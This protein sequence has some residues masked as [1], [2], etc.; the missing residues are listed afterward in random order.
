MQGAGH[1]GLEDPGRD[2][3]QR[4]LRPRQQCRDH[5]RQCRAERRPQHHARRKADLQHVT[6]IANVENKTG[7]VQGFFVP[8]S[9]E[10]G[11]NE[12]GKNEAGK[13][14]PAKPAAGRAPTPTN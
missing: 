1:G 7:R 4:G 13:N 6:G 2:L 3:G 14:T 12:A 9:A 8:N 11:K 5:D 10:A